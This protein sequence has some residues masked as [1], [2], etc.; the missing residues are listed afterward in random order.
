M[1]D[2]KISA[3]TALTSASADDIIPIVD[4]PGGSPVTKKITI[5]NLA[6]SVKLGSL[7]IPAGAMLLP[8]TTPAS[9]I[10]QT[11]SSTNKINQVT[12]DFTDSSTAYA[13]ASVLMPSDYDGGTFT[14]KFAWRAAGTSTN[15]V[16]WQVEA[17]SFGDAETLDQA[18]G[19]AVTVSDA[20]TA[21]AQQVLISAATSAVTAA[22]T[23]A[24]GELMHFRFARLPA[25]G[26]DTLAQTA[27]LIGVQISYTRS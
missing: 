27:L 15:S 4:D 10:N 3:L 25:N 24:G 19:T 26:S 17:R 20:H 1:A 5:A 12:V 7:W 23:P 6:A 13:E 8:T 9:G 21:T 16:V 11:E 14:A 22:G 18:F 2:A